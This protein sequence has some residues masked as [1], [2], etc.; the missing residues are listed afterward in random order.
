M[1]DR[2]RLRV[3]GLAALMDAAEAGVLAHMHFPAVH[4]ARPHGANPVERLDGEIE[5]E[6]ADRGASTIVRLPAAIEAEVNAAEVNAA[7]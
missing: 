1:A 4:P 2:L 7:G 6:A 3:P 5:A